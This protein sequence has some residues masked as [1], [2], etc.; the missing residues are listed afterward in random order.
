ML[1][2][3]EFT[4]GWAWVDDYGSSD[5]PEEFKALL[6]Y[7]PYHNLE[8]A[9]YPATMVTTA[10]TDDR[11]V[12]GHSF[13]FAAQLQQAH[14]GDSPSGSAPAVVLLINGEHDE[15]RFALPDAGKNREWE[16]RFVSAARDFRPLAGN[17]WVLPGRCIV[18]VAL[19]D[20]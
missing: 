9:D 10:D 17:R 11:V 12:P 6:A 8:K 20:A 19:T 5:D 15:A 13:K 16:I 2:F 3:H 14:T 4:I 1:R 7:S 18:C